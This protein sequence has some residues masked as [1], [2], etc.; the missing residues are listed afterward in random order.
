MNVR[1]VDASKNSPYVK[2]AEQRINALS[3]P[4]TTNYYENAANTFVN[5]PNPEDTASILSG[6]ESLEAGSSVKVD[7]EVNLDEESTDAAQ[8][9]EETQ[10]SEE[11]KEE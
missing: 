5:L 11:S 1:A 7:S 2:L 9:A 4:L 10:K 8:D 6:D 3:K